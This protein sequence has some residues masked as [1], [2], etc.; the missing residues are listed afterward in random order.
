[1]ISISLYYD[2]KLNVEKEKRQLDQ[3]ARKCKLCERGWEV[4]CKITTYISDF[5]YGII[6]F[7]RNFAYPTGF[8]F[9]TTD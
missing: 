3:F 5:Q 8:A 7:N 9:K 2:E 4:P 6:L 1:M